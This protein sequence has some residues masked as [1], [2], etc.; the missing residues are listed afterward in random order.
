MPFAAV[1]CDLDAVSDPSTA[2]EFTTRIKADWGKN[3]YSVAV[4]GR[5]DRAVLLG[6]TA[7]SGK[8]EDLDAIANWSVGVAAEE[9][10]ASVTFGDAQWLREQGVAAVPT[11]GDYAGVMV[12]VVETVKEK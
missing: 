6:I 3:A 9:A 2:K 7:A 5:N 4:V 8:Q 1:D 11:P 12:A 10:I